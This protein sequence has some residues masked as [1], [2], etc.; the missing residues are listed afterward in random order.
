[1]FVGDIVEGQVFSI[2]VFGVFVKLDE[3]TY[4][5]LRLPNL[6]ISE[7]H[8]P[9]KLPAVGTMLRC[10]IIGL[11]DTKEG[12]RVD[13]SSKESDFDLFDQRRSSIN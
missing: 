7:E 6:A 3:R 10:V 2:Q 9:D 1:M 11:S 12:L 5:L 8:F 13:L 4:G